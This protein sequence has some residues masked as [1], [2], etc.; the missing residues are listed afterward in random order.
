MSPAAPRENHEAAFESLRQTIK[1]EG[2]L[3]FPPRAGCD[4]RGK[5]TERR[6]LKTGIVE[7]AAHAYAE[8]LG[9]EDN[10]MRAYQ[11]PKNV[12][13]LGGSY[14]FLLISKRQVT[15]LYYARLIY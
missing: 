11:Y 5:L 4:R 9:L 13:A 1:Q 3:Q 14:Q 15:R 6:P 12:W 10:P 8:E 7:Q 2:N